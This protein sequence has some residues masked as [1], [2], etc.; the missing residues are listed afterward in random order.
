MPVRRI[1]VDPKTG[2]IC[3][4]NTCLPS[5]KSRAAGSR[6]GSQDFHLRTERVRMSCTSRSAHV[7]GLRQPQQFQ[8][9]LQKNLWSVVRDWGSCVAHWPTSFNHRCGPAY[10]T[11][12]LLCEHPAVVGRRESGKHL[13]VFQGALFAP[14]FPRASTCIAGT[15]IVF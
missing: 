6:V 4:R 14:S 11:M 9:M 8:V 7:R 5:S 2:R 1:M 10:A 3:L 12:I 13:S 15:G